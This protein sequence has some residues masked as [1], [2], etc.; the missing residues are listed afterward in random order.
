MMRWAGWRF[1]WGI[2]RCSR[3]A[4]I[5]GVADGRTS[6]AADASAASLGQV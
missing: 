1:E 6:A 3:A 2:L 5:N 4:G